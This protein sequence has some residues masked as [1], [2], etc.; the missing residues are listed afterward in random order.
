[1]VTAGR[2]GRT[3]VIKHGHQQQR[4]RETASREFHMLEAAGSTPARAIHHTLRSVRCSFIGSKKT[5]APQREI[6]GTYPFAWQNAHGTKA[7]RARFNLLCM[8]GPRLVAVWEHA[9][10]S[11][12]PSIGNGLSRSERAA[13]ADIS[14]QACR[15]LHVKA[16]HHPPCARCWQPRFADSH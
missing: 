5:P 7:T 10:S 11:A 16:R 14:L 3:C 6:C 2:S 15:R 13:G 8:P 4:G 1:M 12:P 9:V